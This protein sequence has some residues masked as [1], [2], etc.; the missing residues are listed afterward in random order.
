MTLLNS[1][2]Q[3]CLASVVV[4]K[5]TVDGWT[6]TKYADG[7][8]EGCMEQ[9]GT[10]PISPLASTGTLSVFGYGEISAGTLP[11]GI[12]VDFVELDIVKTDGWGW[13][14]KMAGGINSTYR[15]VKFGTTPS[16]INLTLR[17][18]FTGTWK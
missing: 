17:K 13:L 12:T 14:V 15:F 8:C 3:L 7:S 11:S 9:W 6:V 2:L 4:E 5:T 10:V 16:E 1:I 18:K